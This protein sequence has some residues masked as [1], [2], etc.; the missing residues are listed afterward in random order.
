M[1]YLYSTVCFLQLEIFLLVHFLYSWVVNYEYQECPSFV[2]H[3]QL[4]KLV[5]TTIV[6]YSN[7]FWIRTK[8]DIFISCHFS[9][10][11]TKAYLKVLAWPIIQSIKTYLI[12]YS[13]YKKSCLHE[14][15][16]SSW[17][18]TYEICKWQVIVE[19]I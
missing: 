2:L 13:R 5:V 18:E 15:E 17:V 4:S 16:V 6:W 9:S 14:H 19:T 11:S 10:Q 1:H 3:S 8:K 12:Y 7:I